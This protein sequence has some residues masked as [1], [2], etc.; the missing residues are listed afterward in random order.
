MTLY[1][2]ALAAGA[3]LRL[4]VPALRSLLEAAITPVLAA[5]LYATFLGVP[6]NRLR[7][8]F[9]DARFMTALLVVN[10]LV[11][12]AVVLPLSWLVADEPGLLAGT[13]LVLLAPCVDY[14][15]KVTK[16]PF[17]MSKFIFM[18]NWRKWLANFFETPHN[19]P[20]FQ[21]M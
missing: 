15:K 12:P 21:P 1:L 10:F 8:A 6:F 17:L 7:A 5:L 20:F 3:V 18:L 11:M 19:A 2:S 13:L 14:V 9:S 4:T 16:S